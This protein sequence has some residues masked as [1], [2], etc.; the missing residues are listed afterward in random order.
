MLL[1]STQLLTSK[2]NVDVNVCV[3]VSLCVRVC[4]VRALVIPHRHLSGCCCCWRSLAR[5]VRVAMCI[6]TATAIS[7]PA[8][9]SLACFCCFS[10][11]ACLLLTRICVVAVAAANSIAERTRK[12]ASRATAK[13]PA[14]RSATF[15][16][17]CRTML[18][19]RSCAPLAWCPL[20]PTKFAAPLLQT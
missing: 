5:L 14:Q 9:L 10:P 4:V 2:V 16:Q 6:S 18:Q 15:S 19:R 11:L 3:S 20:A 8:C 13:A 17:C 12:R 7:L 1:L